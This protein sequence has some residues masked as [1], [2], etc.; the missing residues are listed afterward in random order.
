MRAL[1]DLMYGGLE[2]RSEPRGSLCPDLTLAFEPA[3]LF[4][5]GD[6]GAELADAEGGAVGLTWA[7]EVQLKG[8]LH[9]NKVACHQRRSWTP[10]P[11]FGAR[12][13]R[14]CR[15]ERRCGTASS[16]MGCGGRSSWV[17]P[18]FEL[19][20]GLAKAFQRRREL[21]YCHAGRMNSRPKPWEQQ[22]TALLLDKVFEYFRDQAIVRLP[23][24]LLDVSR[25]GEFCR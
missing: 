13:R 2:S 23:Q 20:P 10:R 1:P 18:G 8:E 17:P 5:R 11:G 24:L 6:D 22:S 3:R 16:H 7:R 14:G 9:G 21:N 25:G 19:V 12:D 15:G 4:P